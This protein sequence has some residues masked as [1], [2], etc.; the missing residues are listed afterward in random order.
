MPPRG[1]C[2]PCPGGGRG[3]GFTCWLCGGR[4]L[5][6]ALPALRHLTVAEAGTAFGDGNLRGTMRGRD[7]NPETST[8]PLRIPTGALGGSLPLTTPAAPE[9]FPLPLPIPIICSRSG[10]SSCTTQLLQRL[11]LR[12]LLP[13]LMK[14]PGPRCH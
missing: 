3:A 9:K 14:S 10:T 7:P 6:G 1:F 12:S 2:F 4:G 5:G 11:S 13:L 8:G